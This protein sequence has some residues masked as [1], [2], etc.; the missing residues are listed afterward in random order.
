MNTLLA[1][2]LRELDPLFALAFI[3]IGPLGVLLGLACGFVVAV[4]FCGLLAT[5]YEIHSELVAFYK[6]INATA[7][8]LGR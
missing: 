6:L 7:P 2:A 5:L 8:R 3:V 1:I 4:A